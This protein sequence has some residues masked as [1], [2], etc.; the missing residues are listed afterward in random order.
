MAPILV[1]ATVFGVYT[2][3]QD[4]PAGLL[5]A[6]LLAQLILLGLMTAA[7]VGLLVAS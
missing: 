3:R 5:G 7:M 2:F 1:A 4:R 6:I